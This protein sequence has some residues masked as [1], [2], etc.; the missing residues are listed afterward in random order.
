[1]TGVFNHQAHA[2]EIS[3]LL[4]GHYK[5]FTIIPVPLD[6]SGIVKI[7]GTD[8]GCYDAEACGVMALSSFVTKDRTI[9]TSQ[10]GAPIY[11][12]F[13]HP[14]NPFLPIGIAATGGANA[15]Y[16]CSYSLTI[17]KMWFYVP[18]ASVSTGSIVYLL[19]VKGVSI[20]SSGGQL[21]GVVSTYVPPSVGSGSPYLN[22]SNPW[23]QGQKL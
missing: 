8:Q 16:P 17:G 4:S 13:N 14:E 18:A 1:M 3:L 23:T 10:I 9:V 6:N 22:P 11:V 19:L 20:E 7:G 12:C 5:Q 15:Q 2:E 21:A